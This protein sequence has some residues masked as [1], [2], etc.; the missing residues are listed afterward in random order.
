MDEKETNGREVDV[1][2]PSDNQSEV[3][4]VT[5]EESTGNST[6]FKVFGYIAVFISFIFCLTFVFGFAIYPYLMYRSVEGAP[7]GLFMSEPNWLFI[8]PGMLAILFVCVSAIGAIS[9]G[10]NYTAGIAVIVLLCFSYTV[11]DSFREVND[12][13][14]TNVEIISCIGS[15]LE[16]L[17]R[18]QTLIV[19]ADRVVSMDEN[20]VLSV[21]S[22]FGE[23]SCQK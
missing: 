15:G 5:T 19:G 12:I 11:G 4:S 7:S 23:I 6:F 17:S 2:S 14:N 8:V 21:S 9:R 3:E 16:E 18:G 22:K 1:Y 10:Q 20:G 13:A